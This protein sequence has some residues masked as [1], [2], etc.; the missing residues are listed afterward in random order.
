MGAMR[1]AYILVIE[2]ATAGLFAWREFSARDRI[3]WYFSVCRKC[4]NP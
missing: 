1:V 4:D 3:T 2:T